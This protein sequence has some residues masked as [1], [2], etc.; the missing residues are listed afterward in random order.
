MFLLNE[1]SYQL[2]VFFISSIFLEL[3]RQA[4][5]PSDREGELHFDGAVQ[6]DEAA[7][8]HRAEE[9]R[10]RGHP[11]RHQVPEGEDG[12]FAPRS[13]VFGQVL[14]MIDCDRDVLNK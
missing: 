5:R 1:I 2:D 12:G 3:D 11:R 8:L 6:G 13:E 14:I 7:R 10:R 4:G 9:V